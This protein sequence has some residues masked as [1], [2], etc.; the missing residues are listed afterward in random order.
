[1]P[2]IRSTLEI[3]QNAAYRKIMLVRN[4][5][6]SE[7]RSDYFYDEHDNP[8]RIVYT[9]LLEK[10]PHMADAAVIDISYKYNQ[11]GT[12]AE[13]TTVGGN[14]SGT[15]NVQ[16]FIYGNNKKVCIEHKFENGRDAGG[17][18]YEYDSHGNPVRKYYL[19]G[20][21]IEAS[22]CGYEYCCDENGRI[23]YKKET[24][25]AGES[26]LSCQI[27]YEYN[28][29]GSVVLEKSLKGGADFPEY[30]RYFYDE[31]SRLIR[32]E[33]YMDDKLFVTA[34]YQYEFY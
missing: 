17:F 10:N 28:E 25:Y 33:H 2:I 19:H 12:I 13:K 22:V 1:M 32:N 31:D 16:K 27:W 4:P 7:E 30:H 6:G 14:P 11:D 18:S 34:V 26:G 23:S 8:V 29:N 9:S 5:M 15:V 3:P 24:V 20:G 21:K